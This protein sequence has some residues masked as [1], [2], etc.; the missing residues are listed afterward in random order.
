VVSIGGNDAGFSQIVGSCLLGYVAPERQPLPCSR[1]PSSRGLVEPA[2]L[3]AVAREVAAALRRVEGAMRQAGYDD[4]DYAITVLTYPAPIPAAAQ[5]RYPEDARGP[6]EGGCPLFDEDADWAAQVVVPRIN[7]AVTE[8]VES[9]GLG[10]VAVLDLS[11]ALNGHRLCEVGAERV[12]ELRV[13]SWRADG[14]RARVEWVNEVSFDFTRT[15]ESLHPN[16]WG[17]LAIRDCVREAVRGA[18][19]HPLTCR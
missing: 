18:D 9:S 14:V 8:G 10:N 15:Q 13:D 6:G 5:L 17:T 3:A 12:E 16:Y 4:D 19:P 7:G 1:N 11:A 2:E